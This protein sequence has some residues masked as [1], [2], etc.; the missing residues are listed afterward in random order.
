M[1]PSSSA[2]RLQTQ[3]PNKSEATLHDSALNSGLNPEF[4]P[5]NVFDTATVDSH[6]LHAF[7]QTQYYY[8]PSAGPP[9]LLDNNA[10]REQ[11]IGASSK[12]S[13]PP[14]HP[15]LDHHDSSYTTAP[16]PAGISGLPYDPERQGSASSS[17]KL[18]KASW[19]KLK[20]SE[21][22]YTELGDSRRGHNPSQSTLMRL[23]D[24]DIPKTKV[25]SSVFLLSKASKLMFWC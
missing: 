5:D 15:G 16:T 25:K 8:Y 24:G 7:P 17:A 1:H 20:D 21:K 11:L 13:Y 14:P 2:S 23:P 3:F 18:R 22:G 4:E 10:S 9:L 19:S 6:T 12:M